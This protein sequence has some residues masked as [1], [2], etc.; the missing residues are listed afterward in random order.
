MFYKLLNVLGGVYIYGGEPA[1]IYQL[2]QI[3]LTV[4]TK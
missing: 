3:V 1:L 4:I 2:H